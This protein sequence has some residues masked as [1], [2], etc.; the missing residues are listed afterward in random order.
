MLFDQAFLEESEQCAPIRSTILDLDFFQYAFFPDTYFGF[1]ML[2]KVIV[3]QIEQVFFIFVL[4][5]EV[6][7]AFSPAI[8]FTG[9]FYIFPLK[10]IILLRNNMSNLYPS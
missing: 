8:A 2:S 7:A 1:S 5:C 3:V 10:S 9:I 6:A 4:I